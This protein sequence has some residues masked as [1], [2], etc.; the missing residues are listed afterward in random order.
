MFPGLLLLA[1]LRHLTV[2]NPSLKPASLW[3]Y[4][5]A[6]RGFLVAEGFSLEEIPPGAKGGERT[7][8]QLSISALVANHRRDDPSSQVRVPARPVWEGEGF[9]D[10]LDAI[11]SWRSDPKVFDLFVE[12]VRTFHVVGAYSACRCSELAVFMTWGCLE[13]QLDGSI[14]VLTP[15]EH[16]LK[17]QARPARVVLPTHPDAAKCPV[18][19]L[20]RWKEACELHGVPTGPSDPVFVAVRRLHEEKA[21]SQNAK[22]FWGEDVVV[23]DPVGRAL[24]DSGFH[25][26]EPEGVRVAAA[27]ALHSRRYR[28]AWKRAAKDAGFL[29]RH[30]FERVSPHGLR[31]GR[32]TAMAAHGADIEVIS[33]HLRHG[34]AAVTV[35]YVDDFTFEVADVREL[36]ETSDAA[37]R[38]GEPGTPAGKALGDVLGAPAPSGASGSLRPGGCEVSHRG[39]VCGRE[40]VAHVA[41]GATEPTR[42]CQLHYKRAKAGLRGDDLTRPARARLR[43]TCEVVGAGGQM[44]GRST[45]GGGLVLD[46]TT[47]ACSKHRGRWQRGLRDEAFSAP[48]ELGSVHE[49]R[50]CLVA[51]EGEVCS[52]PYKA[53]IEVES[54]TRLDACAMH[55]ERHSP[56][57]RGAELTRPSTRARRT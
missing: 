14:H 35:G 8:E 23:L 18:A 40:V 26:G 21:R 15:G 46:G 48:V 29:P 13:D 9:E 30:A 42:V 38:N 27:R 56:G 1:Y 47:S 55:Y 31:R 2:E 4:R 36:V 3:T 45:S 51:H 6:V 50:T 12:A 32:A 16:L 41:L 11:D 5:D 33:I 54:G 25:H 28:N 37:L 44:C 17:H 20:R 57:L 34:S 53:R 52:K 39:A 43:P 49:G 19:Q 7:P 22:R 10:I 24:S